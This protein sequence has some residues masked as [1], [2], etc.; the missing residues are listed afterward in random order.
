MARFVVR[1]YGGKG[2]ER[3]YRDLDFLVEARVRWLVLPS[4]VSNELG[5][6]T[7]DASPVVAPSGETV[8]CEFGTALIETEGRQGVTLVY[9]F[10]GVEPKIGSIA[11][12]SL[13]ITID[14]LTGEPVIDAP[15]RLL[16]FWRS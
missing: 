7:A 16:G 1:V 2:A 12:G 11:L 9:K 10:D 4:R 3:S 5:I 6:E 8:D 14:K 13:G 15:V